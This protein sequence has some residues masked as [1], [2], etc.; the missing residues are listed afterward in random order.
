MTLIPSMSEAG[1]AYST[2][3]N[4]EIDYSHTYANFV[5]YYD[6]KLIRPESDEWSIHQVDKLDG[7]VKFE[8]IRW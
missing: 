7:G 1:M 3:I 8:A 5:S 6:S 4:C 2:S